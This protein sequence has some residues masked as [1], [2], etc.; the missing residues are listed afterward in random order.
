MAAGFILPDL[1]RPERAYRVP[2]SGQHYSPLVWDVF[3]ITT[4]LTI[5]GIDL[6]LITRKQESERALMIARSCRYL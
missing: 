4:Y 3:V 1:G 5:A 2:I 6:W